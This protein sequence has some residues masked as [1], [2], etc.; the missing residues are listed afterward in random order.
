[1]WRSRSCTRPWCWAAAAAV[2]EPGHQMLADHGLEEPFLAREIAVERA[3]GHASLL[4][5]SLACGWPKSLGPRTAPGRPE[6]T[7]GGALPG[8]GAWGRRVLRDVTW[9]VTGWSLHVCRHPGGQTGDMLSRGS[10]STLRP[11]P[12]FRARAGALPWTSSCCSRPRSWGIV[13]GLTEF[14]PISSTGHLILAGSLLGMDDAKARCSTSRSRPVPSWPSS[15]S[16]GSGSSW[17]RGLPSE[18]QARRFVINV[19]V[20]FL[21]A[22]VLGLLFWQRRSRRTCSRPWWWPVFIVGLRHPCGPSGAK[23]C[24]AWPA[25]SR[26]RHDAAGRA[27]GGPDP[28]PGHD[29]RHQPLGATIIGGMFLWAVAQ[30]GDGLSFFLA[31]PTLIG[32]G[33]YNP[34]Y[35]GRLRCWPMSDPP[36]GC[37]VSFRRPGSA[38]AGC[39]LALSHAPSRPSPGTASPLASLLVLRHRPGPGWTERR[40]FG[41]TQVKARTG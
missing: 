15:W 27:Q 6:A 8:A 28:V 4:A 35:K 9:L 5:T 1:M 32:A 19:A 20:G 12:P 14:L 34:L 30:G 23:A 13:E 7:P 41:L 2:I 3:F 31:I 39:C 33:V 16:H 10:R 37:C 40:T 21:P 25:S 36:W 22:V 17:C 11:L 26:G 29:P 24:P 38:C 18:P